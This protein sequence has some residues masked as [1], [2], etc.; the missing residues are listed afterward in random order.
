MKKTLSKVAIAAVAGLVVAAVGMPAN[1]G[2]PGSQFLDMTFNPIVSNPTW[3]GTRGGDGSCAA[4]GC[5]GQSPVSSA[6]RGVFWAVGSG[7][8]TVGLGN[9]SGIFSGGLLATDFWIKS[10]T[11]TGAGGTYW[12]EAYNSLNGG[13]PQGTGA[14]VTWSAPDVDGCGPSGTP[15]QLACTCFMLSDVW[16]NQG[17]FM[18]ACAKSDTLGNTTLEYGLGAN[19]A[20]KFAPVPQPNITSSARDTVSGDVTLSVGLKGG[21]GNPDTPAE[22]VYTKDGCGTGLAGFRVFGAVVP[23]NGT[24]TPGQ[25]VLLPRADNTTQG[26]TAFGGQVAVKADCNPTLAQ[27]LYLSAQIVGEGATPFTANFI[28]KTATRVPCGANLADPGSRG[29]D[30]RPDRGRDHSR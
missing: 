12:Y 17:Y 30:P 26:T 9:D 6:V 24:P 27:D 2:C 23:R 11:F 28:G 4:P 16:N 22:G 25:F 8:P 7:N 21:D 1:A 18:T 20:F 15:P 29:D 19:G 14:P 3:G 13:Y 5:Y 10:G